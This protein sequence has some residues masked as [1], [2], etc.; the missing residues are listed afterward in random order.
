MYISRQWLLSVLIVFFFAVVYFSHSGT[1][2]I[3]SVVSSIKGSSHDGKCTSTLESHVALLFKEYSRLL[4]GVTHVAMIGYPNHSNKGDSAI[5]TGEKVLLEQLGIETVYAC[6]GNH[7]YRE[8]DLRKALESHGGPEKTAILFHGGGNFG[9]IWPGPELNREQVAT[10]F[11]DYRIRSFPQT[12]K[13]YDEKALARAQKAFSKHPDLQFTARDTKSFMAMQNDFGGQHQ[14][15]LLPDAATMLITKPVPPRQVNSIY[16]MLFL[17]RTDHEGSQDHGKQ[18]DVISELRRI[19]DV[20]GS[21]HE[22]NL[23]VADWISVDPDGLEGATFDQQAQLR[24][25]WTYNYLSE[26]GLIISDRLHV[27]ILSTVWGFDHVSVEEGNYAKLRT[28]HETWLSGCGDRV[29]MTQS[30][31]EAVDAA[32][33]WYKRGRKF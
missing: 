14:V 3:H 1:S 2:G 19:E 5:W 23:T 15:S 17:A 24:V 26:F 18:G 7:D 8:A 4:P 28:Y 16:D 9:D 22:T 21:T 20:D 12:Y 30:V 11:L 6:V 27:H 31:R 33:A 13:F 25:N 10:D 32:K 29:A